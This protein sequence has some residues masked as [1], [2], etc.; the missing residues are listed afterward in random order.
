VLAR[1]HA[2]IEP[3]HLENAFMPKVRFRNKLIVWL[4]LD[5]GIRRGELLGLR[6]A[7]CKLLAGQRTITIHRRPD[8]KAGGQIV[9]LSES[10]RNAFVAAAKP[11]YDQSKRSLR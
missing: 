10:E 2:V 11:L 1:L 6:C 8:G 9:Y 3:D 5:L 7:D 4:L